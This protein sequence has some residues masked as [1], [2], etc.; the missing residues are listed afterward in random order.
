M[1]ADDMTIIVLGKSRAEVIESA[2]KELEIVSY[3]LA[4][5]KLIV[6][7][8][9]TKYMIFSTKPHKVHKNSKLCLKSL[10]QPIC[11]VTEF[12]CL[13]ILI[14][15]N[16]SWKSHMQQFL[17]KLRA[18]LAIVC[19]SRY[20]LTRSCLLA[21]FYSFANTHLNYIVLQFGATTILHFWKICRTVAIKF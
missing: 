14:S 18:C 19:K 9:K 2:N 6:N 15:N 1:Y 3:W 7:P 8:T 17:N 21:L 12:K 5:H 10:S 11:E 4:K 20:Y 16:L 13:G